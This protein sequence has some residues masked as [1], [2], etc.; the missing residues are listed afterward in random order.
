MLKLLMMV[1]KLNNLGEKTFEYIKKNVDELIT[2][3][4]LSIYNS[5]IYLWKNNIVLL[6]ELVMFQLLLL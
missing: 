1:F 5:I 6:K 4:E 3:C 2:V